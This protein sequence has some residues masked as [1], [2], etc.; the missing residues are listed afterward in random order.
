MSKGIRER[1]RA[2]YEYVRERDRKWILGIPLSR[3]DIRPLLGPFLVLNILDAVSTLVAM[4]SPAFRELNPFVAALFAF[5]SGGLVAALVLKYSPAA[6]LT[7][8]AFSR[9]KTGRHP[10]AIRVAKLSAMVVLVV[11]D[12]FYV[13]VVGSNVGNL[14]RLY[15]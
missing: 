6:V 2:R 3:L 15:Y 14:L 5:K 4:Q 7:L 1:M 9:D 13:I 11:G 12:V 10:L 8:I